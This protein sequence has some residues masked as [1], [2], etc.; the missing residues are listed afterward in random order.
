MYSCVCVCMY[1]LWFNFILGLNFMSLCFKT[2]YHTLPYL[3]TKGNKI[4]TKNEI[5]PQHMTLTLTLT[6]GNATTYNF[7]VIKQTQFML[8]N[9][10]FLCRNLTEW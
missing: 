4:E 2:H 6:L 8:L 3:K 5:E 10:C 1:M 7:C 9:V